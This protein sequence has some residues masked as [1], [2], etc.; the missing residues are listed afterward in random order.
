[1]G[2]DGGGVNPPPRERIWDEWKYYG[3]DMG[4]PPGGNRQTDACQNITLPHTSHTGSDKWSGSRKGW[5][6]I[7]E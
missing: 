7:Q 3:M 2:W 4:I 1:M 6:P 5:Q